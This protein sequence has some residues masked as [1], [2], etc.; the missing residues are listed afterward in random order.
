MH[1]YLSHPRDEPFDATVHALTTVSTGGFA[2]YDASFGTFSGPIEYAASVF[3]ILAALPFVRYVQLLNGHATPLYRDTQV[4]A[5]LLTIVFL[6]LVTALVL[7]SIFP[8]HWEQAFREGLFNITSIISGTGFS[9]V[10]YMKWGAFLIAMFF[11]IGLIGGCAGSTTCSV[12][13][14]R[15][16]ILFSSIRTQVKR[17]AYPHGVFPPHYD[18]RPISEDVLNS[19]MSFF[20]FFTVT[21]GL[22]AVALSL[23]GLDFVTS[24]SGAATAIGNIGPGLGDT[25]GPAGNFSTL[26]DSA[27]WILSFAMFI[28]RLELMVV[29]ALFTVGFWRV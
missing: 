26:N 27:K 12:K 25:I 13:I 24:L 18:G 17:T 5:F 11:F 10:D 6:V 16:Q 22:V 8:H 2:N 23:T 7:T 1:S 21:L 14:F 9:S 15:Y 4:R 28:G 3:M 19:V 20:V 29:F